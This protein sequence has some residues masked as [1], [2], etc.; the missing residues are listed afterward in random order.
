MK[1]E[2]KVTEEVEEEWKRQCQHKWK[3][4]FNVISQQSRQAA[5]NSIV[6]ERILETLT[7]SNLIRENSDIGFQFILTSTH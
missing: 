6:S 7:N 4:L 5:R 1:E 3:T 2:I